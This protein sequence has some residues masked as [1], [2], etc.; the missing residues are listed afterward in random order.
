MIWPPRLFGLPV[1]PLF[2][3]AAIAVGVVVVRGG[4]RGGHERVAPALLMAAAVGGL[5][6]AK[7]FSILERG[8][9]VWWQPSW[10]VANGYRYP[11]ALAVALAVFALWSPKAGAPGGQQ[12]FGD[13]VAPGV[14]AAMVVVRV[15]CLL[16]GCCHGVPTDLPW[17]IAFPMYSP[18]WRAHVELGWIDGAAAASLPVH[19]LQ[20]YFA[21]ASCVTLA[22]VLWLR[23]RVSPGIVLAFFLAVDGAAKLGLESLRLG[24][25]QALQWA[26]ALQLCAGVLLLVRC[27]AAFAP[28]RQLWIR[29]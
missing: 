27:A 10:E 16:C 24:N 8:G 11:G 15:G 22:L 3:F 28:P 4:A 1:Y 14:A 19:P 21:L 6:G 20:V 25:H 9:V 18:A 17:A 13:R 23:R 2:V 12:H 26:A 7:L 29:S 5:S